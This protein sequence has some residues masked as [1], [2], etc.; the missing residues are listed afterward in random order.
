VPGE[1]K[2]R[3]PDG[4]PTAGK[5]GRAFEVRSAQLDADT[6]GVTHRGSFGKVVPRPID[7]VE[8][9]TTITATLRQRGRDVTIAGHLR[10]GGGADLVAVPIV[11]Y[12]TDN[13]RKPV[14]TAKTA[15][16]TSGRYLFTLKNIIA[17][18]TYIACAEG[19]GRYNRAQSSEV[20]VADHRH[21]RDTT[22]PT[23][24]A[25]AR[26]RTHNILHVNNPF[27]AND[28]NIGELLLAVWGIQLVLWLTAVLGSIGIDI[29]FIPQL[30]GMVY[31]LFLP[32]ILL[33]RTLRLH[34]LGS[35]E[36]VVYAIGL[37]LAFDMAVGLLLTA[38]GALNLI[39][40]PISLPSLLI[41]FGA[42]FFALSLLAYRRDKNFDDP[43]PVYLTDRALQW[44]LFLAL[45]PFVCVFGTYLMNDYG[46]N[47]LLLVVYVSVGLSM[48]LI[49][50]SEKFPKGLYPFALFV[51]ALVMLFSTSLISPYISGWD[52][53]LEYYN[54][55]L[56]VRNG[57]WD[58]ALPHLYNSVLSVT[59][60]PPMISILAKI[61]L[62][63]VFK[64]VYPLLFA[65]V[66]V[67]LYAVFKR[68][69]DKKIAFLS[70][71]FVISSFTFFIEL[72]QLARQEMAELFFVLV[73][74]VIVSEKIKGSVKT[75][76]LLVFSF[77]LI[78]S[79]YGLALIFIIIASFTVCALYVTHHRKA[80]SSS[81]RT[82][83][84]NH[85][86]WPV[87]LVWSLWQNRSDEL[88]VPYVLLFIVVWLFW[89][90]FVARGTIATSVE[91]NIQ[92]MVQLFSSDV[93]KASS[94]G[95]SSAVATTG[96]LHNVATGLRLL[97][98][99][100]IV[101]GLIVTFTK[102]RDFPNTTYFFF[103]VGSLGIL[104]AALFLPNV[105]TQLNVTRFYH[106]ATLVMAP[107]CLIGGIFLLSTVQKYLPLGKPSRASLIKVIAIFLFVTFLFESNALYQ[108]VEHSSGNFALNNQ[109][110]WPIYNREEATAANWWYV[111]KDNSSFVY[112]DILRDKLLYRLDG[113]L[114]L[115]GDPLGEN[116]VR[117]LVVGGQFELDPRHSYSVDVNAT[118]N[119]S[120]VFLGTKNIENSG[121]ALRAVGGYVYLNL[122][123]T[124]VLRGR[125]E[126]FNNGGAQV[127]FG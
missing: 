86:K 118:N 45:L 37:S 32:G 64:A 41:S 73:L 82:W 24:A 120:Y 20:L 117:L 99:G 2:N 62:T 126:V 51:F 35:V 53:S 56:V 116:H 3:R 81:P 107:F 87:D 57:A 49:A 71:F 100:L 9:P 4:N 89:Y 7:W 34:K 52:I 66:P 94:A 85:S 112:A 8:S 28:W 36:T 91:V 104:A 122:N 103:A 74:L 61:D 59:L 84:V 72:T 68:L 10:S 55:A 75:L 77:S 96:L 5:S 27:Q 50:V 127:H 25:A 115:H 18:H 1:D 29:P 15:T 13:P 67:V 123:Q 101:L 105:A 69:V 46:S 11:L 113:T 30:V 12:N 95:I 22:R 26:G 39:S 88:N 19:R 43:E 106:I 90:T 114:F 6:V 70:A 109:L 97:A 65:F 76:L 54:A 47:A 102:R 33:L 31:V 93:G 92:Y 23:L 119:G 78:V 80:L 58:W 79:H 125:S 42:A 83:K 44:S 40:A 38:A 16:D 14:Q 48:L 17:T 110:D 98:E 21:I 121:L 60:I 108:V 111:N 124:D 63:Y